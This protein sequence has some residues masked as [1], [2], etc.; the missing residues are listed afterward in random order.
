MFNRQV[1]VKDKI[2]CDSWLSRLTTVNLVLWKWFLSIW[3]QKWYLKK[4]VPDTFPQRVLVVSEHGNLKIC[5][6][7]KNGCDT[8][9]LLCSQQDGKLETSQF[10]VY[11]GGTCVVSTTII[12][13]AWPGFESRTINLE[14]VVCSHSVAGRSQLCISHCSNYL[15]LSAILWRGPIL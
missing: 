4:T 5:R 3:K 7:P 14:I 15:F 11:E 1:P 2:L 12:N 10:R 8:G 6:S 13:C 9:W